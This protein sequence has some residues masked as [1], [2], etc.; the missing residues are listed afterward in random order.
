MTFSSPAHDERWGWLRSLWYQGWLPG[1]L[2][3]AAVVFAYQPVW[4]A[5]F[6]WDDDL[7]VTHNRLLTAP[8]GL[9]RIWFSLDSPSQYFPLTYTTFR[10]ERALWGLNPAGYHWVNL[11][12]HAANALLVWRLLRRLS[13]PGAWLAA[14]IFALHPVQVES[15]AWISERKNVLSLC[16]SLLS[17][18]AWV[19]FVEGRSKPARTFY[20]LSLIFY[21]LALCSKATAC[22]L[23][24]A[25]LLILWLK[26]SPIDRTRLAQIVPFVALGAG[27]GLL[28]MW[29]E[30][31]HQGTEG[32]LFS[33]SP[34]DRVLIA[35]RAVWFYTGKLVWPMN[36]TFSYPQWTINS[37]N[38]L[39]YG[40]L[41]AGAG[42]AGLICY[43]R[44]FV[45]R[46]VEVA[47]LF[48]VVTL[49]PLLGFV[50]LYTFTYTFVADHY[51]YVASIGPLALAGAWLTVG[52]GRWCVG[53]PILKPA[54]AGALL[55]TLGVLTWR[56]GGMYADPET[57]WRATIIRNPNSYLAHESLSS[58][59]SRQGKVD[60]AMIH[61]RKALELHPDYAEAH[62]NLG[63]ALDLKG[64]EDA[65][66]I[67]FQ[68]A[69][70]I[71]PT[72]VLAWNGL[73]LVYLKTGKV[74]EAIAQ[75][76]QALKIQPNS[77]RAGSNLG[78]ALAQKGL[79]D[80]A[81]AQ[82]RKV[83]E[84]HPEYAEAHYNLGVVLARSGRLEDAITQFRETI[85][86]QP[87][88]ADAHYNL[89]LALAQKGR[90][91]EAVAQFKEALRIKPD[92][93]ATKER[94]REFGLPVP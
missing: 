43:A 76:R 5:G 88:H 23:P 1:L 80:E 44:R 36:L 19:G 61:L 67:E 15:V 47:A 92:D 16:F 53:K 81:E 25:L 32:G 84:L 8:D 50:M 57:L 41:V 93:P 73:G 65:A 7:Y 11:L 33:L 39:T 6:I 91:D 89:G 27:L 64:Q 77:P 34:L 3:V 45:G 83:L 9:Q 31:Y 28:A 14:A 24:A 10:L 12:L 13:V 86:L 38:P 58:I 71:Q 51:Q 46:G 30:R 2:L 20:F 69:L 29:W 35:S 17:L 52:A 78:L 56:Q 4:H 63:V 85:A 75:F 87:G 49:S 55:L 21:T 26:K 48:Y 40:W 74:D 62:Y 79:T 72:H 59:L 68:T 82:F 22:T 18:L 54:L 60:E 42:L 94:L 90:A 37:A 66:R 70:A